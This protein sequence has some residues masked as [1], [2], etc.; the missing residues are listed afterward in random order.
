MK[1]KLRLLI[2]SIMLLCFTLISNT[3]LL[4]QS[5]EQIKIPN[6]KIANEMP[7][8]YGESYFAL[9]PDKN[10]LVSYD[11][12]GG[13]YSIWH[14]PDG[15]FIFSSTTEIPIIG[16]RG[17]FEDFFTFSEDGKYVRGK[18]DG[19]ICKKISDGT[20]VNINSES[21]KD[22]FAKIKWYTLNNELV[23]ISLTNAEIKGWN[24]GLHRHEKSESIESLKY[25]PDNA[26]KDCILV[27][28]EQQFY[29]DTKFLKSVPEK[30]VKEWQNIQAKSNH[31][32]FT[33]VN[34]ARVN[35][36]TK[37]ITQLGRAIPGVRGKDYNIDDLY[38]SLFFSPDHNY[39]GVKIRYIKEEGKKD[40]SRTFDE[41]VMVFFDKN[42]TKLWQTEPEPDKYVN[43]SYYDDFGNIWLW[44][45]SNDPNKMYKNI[46]LVYKKYNLAT[47]KLLAEMTSDYSLKF[48]PIFDWNLI[49]ASNWDPNILG[50]AMTGLYDINTGN[51]LA[52]L[53]NPQIKDFAITRMKENEKAE[54]EKQLFLQLWHAQLRNDYQQAVN[55]WKKEYKREMNKVPCDLCSNNTKTNND[56]CLTC[57]Y[58]TKTESL[59]MGATRTV[60]V[61][62][63][64]NYKGY[65]PPICKKCGGRGYIEKV[66]EEE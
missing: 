38:G 5:I 8:G 39:Y 15:N 42:G 27:F 48:T 11:N 34:I 61:G 7:S 30:S 17:L 51:N 60:I 22:Y 63:D 21:T 19:S 65:I 13:K 37:E 23:I 59:G 16:I 6:P 35:I 54:E 49:V 62:K 40:N 18:L 29:G 14:L 24:I 12:T 25:M 50:L 47:G 56:F 32:Q 4:A 66:V 43:I 58:I 1:N 52:S 45:K 55:E 53:Y 2:T 44:F 57:G 3:S 10:Y 33:D 28:Y 31:S 26:N 46:E 9:S 36:V 64:P 41:P 20:E